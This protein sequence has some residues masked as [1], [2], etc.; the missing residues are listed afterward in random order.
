MSSEQKP[1]GKDL[2]TP[3][4]IIMGF[5]IIFIGIAVQK[6]SASVIERLT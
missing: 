5:A 4:G 3:V 2:G 6:S 1:K